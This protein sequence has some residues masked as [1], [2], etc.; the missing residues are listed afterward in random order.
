MAVNIPDFLCADIERIQKRAL[1]IILPSLTYREALSNTGITTMK[2]RR[3]SLCSTFFNKN[4]QN[5]KLVEL[6]PEL[7]S[8][9]YDLRSIRAHLIIIRINLIVSKTL[10][11]PKLYQRRLVGLFNT[12]TVF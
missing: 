9:G 5:D 6:F 4:G 7:S 10:F 1:R 8:V 12:F 11:Y 2:D 3:E